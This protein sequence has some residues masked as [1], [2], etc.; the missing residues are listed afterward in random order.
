MVTH[1]D[2]P[3]V[4]ADPIQFVQLFQNLIGNALK[5]CDGTPRPRRGRADR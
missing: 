1:D 2:L 5:F 3:T 4:L